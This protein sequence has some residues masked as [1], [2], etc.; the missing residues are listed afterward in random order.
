MQASAGAVAGVCGAGQ[1]IVSTWVTGRFR[2]P[3]SRIRVRSAPR[4]LVSR[5][6]YPFEPTLPINEA[7]ASLFVGAITL[8]VA[9]VEHHG[10]TV[11]AAAYFTDGLLRV[12]VSRQRIVA[13]SAVL[14]GWHTANTYATSINK[15]TLEKIVSTFAF[16]VTDVVGTAEPITG[17]W[18]AR[19]AI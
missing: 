17:T 12:L 7:H 11:Q 8:L 13:H 14:I 16:A 18:R 19:S 2:G 9:R 6:R 3:I 4:T 15:A 10:V 5:I 1:A